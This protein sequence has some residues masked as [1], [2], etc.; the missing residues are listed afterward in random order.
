M[1]DLTAED[2]MDVL[3]SRYAPHEWA[4]VPEFER[5]DAVAVNCWPSKR[6]DV[7]GI[8]IKVSRSDWLRELKRPQKSMWGRSISDY[9]F[10]AAPSG[11][12]DGLDELPEGWG[13][14]EIQSERSVLRH[15]TDRLRPQWDGRKQR[16]VEGENRHA[17][18][19]EYRARFLFAMMARRFVYADAD[20]RHLAAWMD[21]PT[22]ALNAAAEATN[23]ITSVQRERIAEARARQ[24]VSRA[25]NRG[26]HDDEPVDGCDPCE[27]KAEREARRAS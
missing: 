22:D 25:H 11:V 1:A 8:E 19:P 10:L 14:I 3:R 4:L 27:W 17:P 24:R 26:D 7:H 18:C 6:L 15:Q 2:V 21:D 5:V 12:L 13:Y 16:P 20:A 9:W 23:R